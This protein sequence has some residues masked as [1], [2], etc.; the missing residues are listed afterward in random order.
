MRNNFTIN[1]IS[2]DNSGRV[3][4]FDI[5]DTTYGNVYLPSGT[6]GVPRSERENYFAET[7]LKLLINCKPNG[8]LGGD[9][10]SIS[11]PID[12]TRNP[13]S[14]VSPSL[15]R[16]VSAFS[17][18]DSFRC[19]HPD[20]KVFS[21][22]YGTGENSGATR[23]DT[24]FHW[25]EMIPTESKYVSVSLSDHMGFIVTMKVPPSYDNIMGPKFRPTFKIKPDIAR[26]STLKTQVRNSMEK[27]MAVR[28]HCTSILS[29]WEM[30]LKP[31]LRRLAMQ[32]SREINK[33]VKIKAESTVPPINLSDFKAAEWVSRGSPGTQVCPTADRRMV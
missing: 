3:I 27:W 10:N 29:W 30:C 7:L 11:N 16:L 32:R 31:N 8:I 15:K 1:N 17:W 24:S 6:D 28:K 2:R 9:L 22:Y 25:E 21:H 5:N 26:D 14:T 23:I 13:N 12:C 4:I 19:L 33:T 20:S 18:T